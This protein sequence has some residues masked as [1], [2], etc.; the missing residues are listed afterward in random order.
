MARVMVG[1][2]SPL[3]V[4]AAATVSALIA[5][6]LYNTTRCQK[7]EYD[8]DDPFRVEVHLM[9]KIQQKSYLHTAKDGIPS[10]LRI[11]AIDLPELR[12]NAFSGD[13]RLSHNHVFVD[14]VAPSKLIAVGEKDDSTKKEKQQPSLKIAQKA[15]I[16]VSYTISFLQESESVS[17]S[18]PSTTQLFIY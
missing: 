3:I 13:C 18:L 4:S 15:L 10:T 8:D 11:L 6:T 7:A 9:D 2:S 5:T 1:P 14:D 17:Q 16:K 12:K